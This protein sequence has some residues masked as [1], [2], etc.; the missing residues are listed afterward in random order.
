[1]I[2]LLVGS[3]WAKREDFVVVFTN[4]VGYQVFVPIRS[5]EHFEEDET[6]QLC[7]HT[8][9]REDVIKLFGFVNEEDL[10]MF[11]K[12]TGTKGIGPSM[13]MA[14]L[15]NL[16]AGEIAD[17]IN[18]HKPSILTAIKGVGQKKAASLII[19]LSGKLVMPKFATSGKHSG[20]M[21]D[22]RTALRRLDFKVGDIDPVLQDLAS[23]GAFEKLSV[24]G[25]ITE[26]LPLILAR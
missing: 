1:M 22:V 25:L 18:G 10:N 17:A 13:A 3:V 7:I 4:G 8:H 21:A 11:Q 16:S 9:V 20:K 15:S 24:E 2:A 23:S 26:A 14:L 12:L 5:L 19:E 6:I